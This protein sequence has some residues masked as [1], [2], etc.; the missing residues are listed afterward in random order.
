MTILEYMSDIIGPSDVMN[1][2]STYSLFMR[3]IEM[4]SIIFYSVDNK[5]TE[6]LQHLLASLCK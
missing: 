5:Y 1:G 2:V 3:N 4:H 6:C